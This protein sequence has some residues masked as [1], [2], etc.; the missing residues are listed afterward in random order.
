M[1]PSTLKTELPRSTRLRKVVLGGALEKYLGNRVQPELKLV[2]VILG[3]LFATSSFATEISGSSRDVNGKYNLGI[4]QVSTQGIAQFASPENL[5]RTLT[6][7]GYG[8]DFFSDFSKIERFDVVILASGS[9][10]PR[11]AV[12]PLVNY[13]KAGGSFLLIGDSAFGPNGYEILST[14]YSDLNI[15]ERQV[16]NR[17]AERLEFPHDTH[18]GVVGASPDRIAAFTHRIM[19]EGIGRVSSV[20]GQQIVPADF[21][22]DHPPGC[23]VLPKLLENENYAGKRVFTRWTPLLRAYSPRGEYVGP[24]AAILYNHGGIY[25][26]SAFAYW[27]LLKPDNFAS[28]I[29][30]P[31]L[32]SLVDRLLHRT[33]IHDLLPSSYYNEV[34]KGVTLGAKVTNRGRMA[35]PLK[36]ELT[37]YR[38]DGRPIHADSQETILDPRQTQS[39]S[40][41]WPGTNA[42]YEEF[43][44]R[45]SLNDSRKILD[46][47][48]TDFAVR[49]ELVIDDG[50]PDFRADGVWT[51]AMS[52]TACGGTYR[53]TEKG[54]GAT[55]RWTPKIR[56]AGH[57]DVFARWVSKAGGG[58]DASRTKNA[59]YMHYA[60]G[61]EI[62]QLS[63]RWSSG[64]WVYLGTPNFAEG[65][66][67]W[68]ELSSAADGS[69]SADAVKFVYTDVVPPPSHGVIRVDSNG[70]YFEFED[71]TP[72]LPIGHN[73]VRFPGSGGGVW[74][75]EAQYNKYFARMQA[76]GENVLRFFSSGVYDSSG[77]VSMSSLDQLHTVFYAARKHGIYLNPALHSFSKGN[78]FKLTA[79][80]NQKTAQVFAEE[81][82]GRQAPL[83]SWD[84]CNDIP[85]GERTVTY[86]KQMKAFLREFEAPSKH[87][88]NIQHGGYKNW[89]SITKFKPEEAEVLDF[90][91]LRCY[92]LPVGGNIFINDPEEITKLF[93][94]RIK[95]QLP[96]VK[97]PVIP[98]E[99]G[100]TF[101]F[102]NAES[103]GIYTPIEDLTWEKTILQGIWV[104]L[105][106]GA[107]PA[108]YF[109]GFFG[110][111]NN[112]DLS[113]NG[114]QY[115][116]ALSKFASRIQ[117]NKFNSVNCDHEIKAS[118]DDIRVSAIRDENLLIG[119]LMHDDPE[120]NFTEVQPQIRITGGLSPGHYHVEWID[121]RTSEAVSTKQAD[122]P[123]F[124]LAA[125]KFKDG[126]ALLLSTAD[127]L[128]KRPVAGKR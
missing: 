1:K 53:T 32:L 48:E 6:D 58:P 43:R 17:L 64:V 126:L 70:R 100:P 113:E 15:A 8:A 14:N 78:V 60:K 16:T 80:S 120:N 76:H 127:S 124:D 7:A 25:A 22:I 49:T 50:D 109:M 10:I 119:F 82:G 65:S 29:E 101:D 85:G 72:F 108:M 63:Q 112:P 5:R 27:G 81:F 102:L 47:Q 95:N 21:R 105:A 125:P 96:L 35:Q 42:G 19:R 74:G 59:R 91:T 94:G 98:G 86:I 36:V 75:A 13:L 31:I 11:S 69:V 106:S 71:G 24:V 111:R 118:L 33:F 52:G 37:I 90:T 4:F 26:G 92:S 73:F 23:S 79:E 84:L 88:I 97:K 68:V 77:G 114:Y 56:H 3:I 12:D 40:F 104:S 54:S 99:C 83:F 51:T 89:E 44:A 30:K 103:P 115:Y 116:A 38:K 55:A 9:F 93:N 28:A 121:P 67:G 117:W 61:E 122:G 57:Y 128:S 34:G 46:G 87:L 39:L 2:A 20:P 123:P 107:S 62:V 45:L 41:L 66:A 110:A 18:E